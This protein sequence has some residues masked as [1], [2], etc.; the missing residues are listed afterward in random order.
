VGETER[1]SIAPVAA[2]DGAALLAANLASLAIHEPFVQPCRDE[3]SFLAYLASCDGVR[4]LGFIARERKSGRIAGIVNVS[5]IVR[6]PLQSAFLGYYGTAG[7]VGRGLMREAVG[8]V[9]GHCFTEIG[10]HRLEANIQPENA[11]SLALARRL[12]FRREGFS[13]R[14]LMIGGAWRDHER[15]ALLAEDW[16]STPPSP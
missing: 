15:W 14:Y 9:V 8:W 7:C 5:E 1:L 10:L 12:G 3:A 16:T 13:P 4:K 11:A 2:G 6:G